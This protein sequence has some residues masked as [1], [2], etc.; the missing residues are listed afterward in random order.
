MFLRLLIILKCTLDYFNV[1]NKHNE[2]LMPHTRTLDAYLH[3]AK[4][5]FCS[6]GLTLSEQRKISTS[7]SP[8]ET[9]IIFNIKALQKRFAAL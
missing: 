4:M 1:G 5:Q 9:K 3:N 6:N 2:K 8:L 7:T